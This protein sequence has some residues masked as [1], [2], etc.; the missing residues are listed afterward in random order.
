MSSS[1][2]GNLQF[3]NDI[4]LGVVHKYCALIEV[5]KHTGGKKE[6]ALLIKQRLQISQAEAKTIC[7]C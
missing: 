6:N 4:S 2:K 5:T 1:Q 7:G 3:Q